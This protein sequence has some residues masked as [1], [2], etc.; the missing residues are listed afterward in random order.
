VATKIKSFE[1]TMSQ[2]DWA[3]VEEFSRSVVADAAPKTTA[4]AVDL[5]TAVSRL[6]LWCHKSA[7]YPL[8]REVVFDRDVISEYVTHGCPELRTKG[9]RGTRRS[10]LLR[11]AESVLPPQE[12]VARLEALCVANPRAPYT[13]AEQISLR[14]WAAGQV[15]AQ[16]RQDCHVLLALG[17]GA[18]LSSGE[19]MALRVSDI[20][21]DDEGVLVHVHG[22]RDR[23]VPVLGHWEPA[24][25][26]LRETC[27]PAE[28]ALGA[29][30]TTM[31]P[32]WV[33]NFVS[34]TQG[35]LKPNSQR[36]RNTWIVHHLTA[37]TP[38]YALV[39]AAGLETTEM[40][41]RLLRF[42]PRPT[43]DEVRAALRQAVRDSR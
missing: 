10:L 32:N 3:A 39:V 40:L 1:P 5:L 17:L 13:E 7:G 19:M 28:P 29:N 12:R 27:N 43:Q 34:K 38:F 37:R 8:E 33:S 21:A 2:R 24:L 16:R 30:R 20:E 22:K 15:T 25:A 26:N 42:V 36:M 6:A 14:S 9:S 31:N 11:V 35:S 41:D 18:G 23:V 4:A